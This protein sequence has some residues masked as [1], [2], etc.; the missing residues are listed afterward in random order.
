[1]NLVSAR[2]AALRILAAR[3]AMLGRSIDSTYPLADFQR[4]GVAHAAAILQRRGGVLIAHSVG[5]GK[6]F[7]A[8]ALIEQH[9]GAGGVVLVLPSALRPMWRRALRPLTEGAPGAIRLVTHGQLSRG[10][11]CD[12]APNLVVVDEAHA[13]RNRNTRRYR[14]LRE[15]IGRARVVLLT[16]TPVNNSLSDLYFQLRL[17]APDDAFRDVGI[18]SLR[19]LLRGGEEP[20]QHAVSRLQQAVMIRRTRDEV[21]QSLQAVRMAGGEEVRFPGDVRLLNIAHPPLIEAAAVE[22][23]LDATRF[24]VYRSDSTRLLISL[25]LLK[26]LQSGRHAAI[27]SLGRLVDFH[28]RFLGAL[29]EGRLLEAR[30]TR[31]AGTDQLWFSELILPELPAGI[32]AKLLRDQVANDLDQLESFRK[33]VSART[34]PKLP[35]LAD[36]LSARPLP[37]RTL[38]FSEFAD[39]AESL[40]S[41][42]RANHQAGLI[43]GSEARLG[44]DR[45]TRGEVIR[46]FAPRANGSPEPAAAERV[47]VLIATDVLAEGLNL[48]DADAVVSYD[49]PWNPVRLIQRAGRIDRI[50]SPHETVFVYN[51]MPDRDLDVL[52]GLVRRLR[53]KLR[54][55]RSAVGEEGAV[56][57][58]NEVDAG[59]WHRLALAD[60]DALDRSPGQE[61]IVPAE[62]LPSFALESADRGC[63]SSISARPSRVLTCWKSQ[64]TL[65]ELI[66]DGTCTMDDKA[67]VDR[68]LRKAV[69][70]TEIISGPL[71][72]DAIADCQAYLLREARLP[73]IDPAISVLARAIQR[74][75]MAYGLTAAPALMAQA[76]AALAVVSGCV[77]PLPAASRIRSAGTAADLI[78]ILSRLEQE[79]RRNPFPQ[80]PDWRL[81]AAIASD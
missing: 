1:V 32:N 65:R 45:C 27:Q 75:V 79:C 47:H 15:L 13:F 50:G 72:L 35:A 36:L 8:A 68:M 24:A 46:R 30:P 12:G 19:A 7:I 25:S 70:S 16:A 31:D 77:E 26:R 58:A 64:N 52:L 10:F 6:T 20:D 21:R 44:M 3:S 23:F 62:D 42:L 61:V 22:A 18:A 53:R 43:T 48:Q 63:V 28:R 56:L 51:F 73:G 14:G 60:G 29:G 11:V 2:E 81:V 59:F 37:A 40:W 76:E 57:E 67:A 39:T 80:Y 74:S 41:E 5:L 71:L 34:D 38:I 17:F 49:L 66:W 69:G 33:Q 4:E 55:V 78:G 9:L 54:D